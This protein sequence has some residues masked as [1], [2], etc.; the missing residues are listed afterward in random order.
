MN[1]KLVRGWGTGQEVN[2]LMLH[3]PQVQDTPR[4]RVGTIAQT[5]ASNVSRQTSGIL[6][7]SISSD[8]LQRR[9]YESTAFDGFGRGNRCHHVLFG[10]I[11]TV[12][13][14]LHN[15]PVER[16]CHTPPP[17]PMEQKLRRKIAFDDR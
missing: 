5:I 6:L 2:D 3:P 14:H 8:G 15:G 13:H 17:P 10:N 16:L 4:R 7:N 11:L 12:L 1:G 9:R